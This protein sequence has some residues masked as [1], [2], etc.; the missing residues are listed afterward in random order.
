MASKSCKVEAIMGGISACTTAD[1]YLER[2]EK[3]FTG[4]S[5][6]HAATL[7]KTIETMRYTGGGIRENVLKISG[8]KPMLN[9]VRV[10]GGLTEAK[11]FNPNI[12]KLY[13]KIVSCHSIGNPEKS[14]SFQ[15]Y[16]SGRYAKFVETRHT[17]F[18]EDEMIKGSMVPWEIGLE[19]KRSAW[20]CC[21]VAGGKRA[22][23]QV[24]GQKEKKEEIIS[25]T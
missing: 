22:V 1:E 19:E 18:L 3:Q 6:A 4:S 10:W 21:D 14:K 12:G 17:I 25:I 13:P 2:V 16:C 7:V 24:E 20:F 11:L 8:R 15:F 9:H 23:A 5:K